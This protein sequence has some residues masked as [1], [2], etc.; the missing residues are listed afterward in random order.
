MIFCS[1]LLKIM[2]QKREN[3]R[4]DIEEQIEAMENLHIVHKA[5]NSLIN[6][7]A[8]EDQKELDE[9]FAEPNIFITPIIFV[10]KYCPKDISL[11]IKH[12]RLLLF[13]L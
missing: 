10:E 7:I 13:Y 2:E 3:W 6:N 4:S 11:I 8:L 1:E 5:V 12:L 9:E